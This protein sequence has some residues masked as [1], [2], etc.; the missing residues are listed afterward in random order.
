MGKTQAEETGFIGS[1]FKRQVTIHVA[2]DR[3]ADR[4]SETG[5]MIEVTTV[6][7]AELVEDGSGLLSLYSATVV[8]NINKQKTI[9]GLAAHHESPVA[10]RCCI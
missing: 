3:P 2:R 5:T 8:R 4:Q 9:A 10:S 7:A 1:K 6:S